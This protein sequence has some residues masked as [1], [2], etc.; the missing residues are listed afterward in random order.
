MEGGQ[1]ADRG[2]EY[3][4]AIFYHDAEQKKLAEISKKNLANEKIFDKP[5][6]TPIVPA[7]IFYPA[8]DYHQDYY[9]KNPLRYRLYRFG[10]GRD[11][12]WIK[13]GKKE[14]N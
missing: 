5:I 12:S 13:P 8:E 4:T 1:F 6:V 2:K 11:N 10:S 3:S 7:M 14:K 9:K